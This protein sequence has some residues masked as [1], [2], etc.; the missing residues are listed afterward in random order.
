MD[1]LVSN[2]IYLLQSLDSTTKE[3]VVKSE[4]TGRV[5]K[6]TLID[7]VYDD[8]KTRSLPLRFRFGCTRIGTFDHKVSY[9]Y[10]VL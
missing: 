4:S 9:E 3:A 6:F 2:R 7:E 8:F 1:D 5:F 10:T